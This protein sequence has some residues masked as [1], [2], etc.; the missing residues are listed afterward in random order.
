MVTSSR[1]SIGQYLKLIAKPK[2]ERKIYYL[3]AEYIVNT[4]SDP[5]VS[6][7][8]KSRTFNNETKIIC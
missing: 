6:K 7:R 5:R 1:V 8:D 4:K 2:K 3:R